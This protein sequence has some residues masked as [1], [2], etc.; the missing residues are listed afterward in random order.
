MTDPRA[1]A[2]RMLRRAMAP[3]RSEVVVLAYH[4]VFSPWADT[5]QMC[6][7]PDH[8]ADH[9]KHIADNYSVLSLNQLSEALRTRSLPKRA[10][11]VT[12]D[13]GYVDFLQAAWPILKR[14][15]VPVS[16]FVTTGHMG[17]LDE[18][19]WDQL[20]RLLLLARQLPKSLE[21]EFNHRKHRWDISET[22]ELSGLSAVENQQYR[23]WTLESRPLTQR[24]SI[25]VELY[26]LLRP[27]A[28]SE[29]ANALND[30][31]NQI[32]AVPSRADYRSLSQYEISNLAQDDL[33]D[34]GAH[35]ITHPVLATQPVEIQRSEIIGSKRELESLLNRRVTS[36]AYPYG[37]KQ[38][39]NEDGMALAMEAGYQVGCAVYESPVTHGSNPYFIPR[40]E[41][42]DSTVVDFARDLRNSF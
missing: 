17:R 13:D 14:H 19:W 25:F 26:W 2:G 18:F 5:Y 36:F 31:L 3:F 34:I 9:M 1:F 40:V 22:S 20:E 12:F 15:K 33:I 35:T 8:F 27:L 38:E 21:V 16:L 29:R 41:V 6:V 42:H 4:R 30:L 24:Q 28:S 37:G 10:V 11:I 23:Q 7:T 32:S 39:V